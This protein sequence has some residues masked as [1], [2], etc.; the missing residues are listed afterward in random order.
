MPASANKQASGSGRL[1]AASDATGH[2][3]GDSGST[4]G[5]S[6][7]AEVSNESDWAGSETLNVSRDAL[8]EEGRVTGERCGSGASRRG[9]AL[10][11]HRSRERG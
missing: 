2:M 11:G 6:K 8:E 10:R 3:P 7:E 1:T 9:R 5:R 4:G